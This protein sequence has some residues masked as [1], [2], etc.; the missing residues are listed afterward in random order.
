MMPT[1]SRNLSR[2]TPPKATPGAGEPVQRLETVAQSL[3]RQDLELRA[4]CAALL[5]QPP[6]NS[7]RSDADLSGMDGFH[8]TDEELVAYWSAY[9]R[10]V[11]LDPETEPLELRT[12]IDWL[13]RGED[14]VEAVS[15]WFNEA[16]QA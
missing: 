1:L 6:T 15:A 13:D 8:A 5:D 10:A 16:D 9:R 7:E 14:P 3:S 4:R 2:V 12:V 11:E